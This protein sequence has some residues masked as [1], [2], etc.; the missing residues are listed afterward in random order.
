M[1]K[2]QA[3]AY[4]LRLDEVLKKKIKV[5]AQDN[6]RSFRGQVENILKKYVVDYEREHGEITTD[7]KDQLLQDF[8]R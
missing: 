4:P 7:G 8:E 6:D 1:K 3:N 5:L 2:K